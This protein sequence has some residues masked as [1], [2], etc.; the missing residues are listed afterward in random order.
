MHNKSKNVI[1]WIFIEAIIIMVMIVGGVGI[2]NNENKETNMLITK[3]YLIAEYN[4]TEDEIEDVD[5]DVFIEELQLT[6][7]N[8]QGIDMHIFLQKYKEDL[9]QKVNENAVYYQYI[10]ENERINEK[11]TEEELQT[12]KRVALCRSS[13]TDLLSIIIDYEKAII[14]YG[15]QVYLLNDGAVPTN[16]VILSEE[17]IENLNS[18]WKECEVLSWEKEYIGTSEGTTGS[19][20]WSLYFELED[21]KIKMYHGSGVLGDNTPNKFGVIMTTLN[22]WNE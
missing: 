15:K 11:L 12:I 19:Y 13:G 2:Y 4:L 5:L 9:N 21:G 16:E 14:Y 7:E 10:T 8:V 6:K 3:E 17:K 1:L 20:G 18:M 22:S